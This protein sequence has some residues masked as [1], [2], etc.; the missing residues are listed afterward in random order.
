MKTTA[1]MELV[2]G[3]EA[4]AATEELQVDAAA[5]APATTIFCASAGASWLASAV[6]AKTFKG[7]C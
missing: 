3:Y 7:G 6:S 1:I 4:Y 2:A 5:D